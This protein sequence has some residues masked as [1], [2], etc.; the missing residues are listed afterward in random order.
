VSFKGGSL[1]IGGSPEAN[2]IG[3][4]SITLGMS[5]RDDAFALGGSGMIAQPVETDKPTASG[6]FVADF[7]DNTNITRVTGL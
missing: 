4:G 3:D 2:I 1:S 5:L 6:T 7:V